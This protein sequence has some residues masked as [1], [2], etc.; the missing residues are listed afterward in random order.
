MS[1][2]EAGTTPPVRPRPQVGWTELAVAVLGYIA[3]C[4]AVGVALGA[5]G[6]SP[7]VALAVAAVGVATLGAV[8][9]ALVVRV[10][11]LAPLRLRLPGRRWLLVGLAAGAGMRVVNY[12]IALVWTT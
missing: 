8:G 6:R 1:T 2:L 4:V 5:T 12:A 3:L 10:R 7:D 9:L 11:S